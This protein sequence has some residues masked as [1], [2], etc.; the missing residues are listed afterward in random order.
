MLREA[1]RFR[2][3]HDIQAGRKSEVTSLS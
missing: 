2:R 1:K 3:C